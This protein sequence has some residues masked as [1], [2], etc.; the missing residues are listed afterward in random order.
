MP[1][2]TPAAAPPTPASRATG[3]P[4]WRLRAAVLALLGLGA[5]GAAPAQNLQQLY[6]AARGY[7]AAYLSE[8]A[9][10]YSPRFKAAQ[11]N[12]LLM[13]NIALSGRSTRS[14]V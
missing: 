3:R 9:L 4:R 2:P 5:A 10:A 7:D 1:V 13:P 14:E 8:R 12:A 6:E 11:A